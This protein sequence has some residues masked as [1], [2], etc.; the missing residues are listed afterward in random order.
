[1]KFEEVEERKAKERHKRKLLEAVML[2]KKFKHEELEKFCVMI[3]SKAWGKGVGIEGIVEGIVGKIWDAIGIDDEVADVGADN[4]DDGEETDDDGEETTDDDDDEEVWGV[5]TLF[6]LDWWESSRYH[7]EGNF[8]TRLVGKSLYTV[9]AITMN[10]T[11][12]TAHRNRLPV[13]RFVSY[14]FR[15]LSRLWDS[16]EWMG[17]GKGMWNPSV[18]DDWGEGGGENMRGLI[19]VVRVEYNKF[20]DLA[21][22]VKFEFSH[23]RHSFGSHGSRS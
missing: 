21:R 9:N 5:G 1:M 23:L 2:L 13:R 12:T 10:G 17:V 15:E 16:I 4:A 18:L 19:H 3:P 11:R 7:D 8:C 22:L 20:D 6:H 14:E